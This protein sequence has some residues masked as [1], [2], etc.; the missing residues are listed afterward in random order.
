[1]SVSFELQFDSS[2]FQLVGLIL[3]FQLVIV[4][5]K[6]WVARKQ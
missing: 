4:C 6:I 2:V 3:L 1:M 5:L